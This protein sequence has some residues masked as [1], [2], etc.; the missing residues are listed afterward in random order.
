MALVHRPPPRER[1]AVLATVCALHGL[2]LTL[3]LATGGTPADLP[4]KPGPMSLLSLEAE[5][6]AAT[7]PPPPS[8]PS[9]IPAEPSEQ[10][11]LSDPADSSTAG[12]PAAGCATLEAVRA[13]LLAEPRVIAAV[14]NAPEETRSIADAIVAWNAGWNDAAATI[15]APIGAVRQVADGSLS[16]LDP[17]CLEEMVIGPR[18]IAVPVGERTVF[19]VFG[20]GSW[21]WRDLLFD[22]DQ[23][24]AR[25]FTASVAPDVLTLTP[26]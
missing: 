17:A 20:S 18:F 5:P 13:S 25:F 4:A 12:L 22:S 3:F 21:R 19:L 2:A 15:D 6:V 10:L 16:A 7:P 8:L 24:K 26:R 11:V 14:T 1:F 9:K 23:A